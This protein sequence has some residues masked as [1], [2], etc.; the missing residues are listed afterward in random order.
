MCILTTSRFCESVS[1]TDV[2]ADDEANSDNGETATGTNGS[3]DVEVD[4]DK[5]GEEAVDEGTEE[6]AGKADGEAE[7]DEGD[8][9]VPMFTGKRLLGA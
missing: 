1:A 4:G 9:F 5:D 2:K 3:D 8:D 7:G 6:V